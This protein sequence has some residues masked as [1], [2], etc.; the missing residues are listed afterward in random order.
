MKKI[1]AFFAS[2][3]FCVHVVA[4]PSPDGN[5]LTLVKKINHTPVK[6]QGKTGTCWSFST[7]SL[8]ESETMRENLGEVDLSEIFIVRNIYLDKAKNYVLRQGKAQFGPGGLGNDVIN[9]MANYGAMPENIY[10]GLLLGNKTHDHGALDEKLKSYLD[11]MLKNNA[12]TSDWQEGF[13]AILDDHLG[14]VPETFTYREKVYTPKTFASEVLKFNKE[15]YVF[16]TS[17][18]HHPY[19][20]RFILEIPDNYG[21]ESYYNLPL[22]E[23][24]AVT[25]QAVEK[26]YSVMW[27]ADVS[28]SSFKQQKIGYA[29]MWKN[30]STVSDPV[31]PDEQESVYNAEIR[32]SLFENLTTQDDHLMHIVGLEKSKQGKKF[33]LVKNSWG[34]IGPFKGYVKVSPAYFAINTVTLVL[35]KEALSGEI[36]T[37]LGLK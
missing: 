37:K 1:I 35:P 21:S 4:Q 5:E 26:G 12:V 29:M 34:E 15:D 11:D 6:S 31:N 23:L 17:F 10:S 9:A 19:Y 3:A 7:V 20:S 25:E 2:I 13:K 8:V 14:K 24:M 28:N 16:I 22:N 30:P 18:T 27:D 36:K 32:Q 33:F